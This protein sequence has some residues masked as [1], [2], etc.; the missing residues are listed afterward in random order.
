MDCKLVKYTL[1]LFDKF[2]A[3]P[4]NP[5]AMMPIVHF[6]NYVEDILPYK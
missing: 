5:V 2:S 4:T 6:F 3:V 1:I